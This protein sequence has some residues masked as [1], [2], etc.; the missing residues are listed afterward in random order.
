MN[1]FE[2]LFQKLNENFHAEALT[3]L[4]PLSSTVIP[5]EALPDE[6]FSEGILGDGCGI[7]PND[8]T[9][10]AP[11]DGR[12]TQIAN[13]LHAIGLESDDGLELLIHVGMDTVE[14]NG[15]GF[16]AMVRQSDAVKAGD[17]LLKADLA[18]IHA[19]GHPTATAVIVT[20]SDTLI[21]LHR[22]SEGKLKAGTPLLRAEI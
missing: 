3:V 11:F 2:T 20:N 14:M 7:E 13:T 9:V 1:L 17:P 5:L 8:G 4:A 21:A 18:A 12:V 19:E 15:R 16:R 22:V 6:T 10:Y